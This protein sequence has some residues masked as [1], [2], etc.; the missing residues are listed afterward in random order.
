MSSAR[1]TSTTFAVLGLL[2]VR[3]WSTYEL[4]RQVQRSLGRMWPR[5]E[6][7][8]YDEPKKLVTLGWATATTETVGRRPRTV[9][10]ITEAGRAALAGWLAEPGDGPVLEFEQ[11][12]KLA[13]ADHGTREDALRTIAAARDW[14]GKANAGNLAAAREYAA[15]EGPYQHRAAVPM[16][17][18]A[19]F[20]DFYAMV[21]RWADW[22]T[23][24]V[25]SWPEN[26]ADAVADPA[27]L[28]AIARKA[29][30][31]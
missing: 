8:L 7:R 4:T 12:V 30:W 14:A 31:S 27:E 6:S 11:L 23:E 2:A 29:D 26:P 22:A 1:P 28:T 10:A 25:E 13:Y 18:G 3:S 9:Y 19:F 24:Q 16:L 15:G 17:A 20:T 5:A 21:A